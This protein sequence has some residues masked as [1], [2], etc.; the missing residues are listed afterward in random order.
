MLKEIWSNII[1]FD[2]I[3]I[4]RHISPDPDAL[5]SQLGLAA[6]IRGNYPNKVVKTVGFTEPSLAWMGTMDEVLDEEYEGALVLV[7]D[8]ANSGR[9]DDGRYQSGAKCIKIDHHPVV[10]DYADL[11]YVSTEASATSEIIVDLFLAN[12]DLHDLKMPSEAAERLYTGIIADSGRFLYDSTTTRTLKA[13][14]FLYDCEIDRNKIHDLLYRRSLNI[15]QAQ[16]YVLSQFEVSQAGVAHFKM[17]KEVQESYGLTTGTRSALVN[18]L[19]NIEGITVWVCFFE[20]EDGRIR[21]NIRSNG[22]VINEVAAMF[23]GGG[24]PKASGAMVNT[25]DDCQSLLDELE[26]VC[27][28]EVKAVN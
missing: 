16:G 24:H 20:N 23:D 13:A 1:A 10:E 6:L 8:T 5:G 25:W 11:N 9:I 2:K 17:S 18:T 7:M 26:K 27:Q 3:I 14:S 22:P 21:A 28:N 12:Q 4:H 15:V 19:A